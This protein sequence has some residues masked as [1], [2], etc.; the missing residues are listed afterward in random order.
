MEAVQ[1]Q[2]SHCLL[3]EDQDATTAFLQQALSTAFPGI[4]VTS[5]RNLRDAQAWLWERSKLT[6][7]R[8]PLPLAL[9]DLGLP[10]GS[11]IELIRQLKVTE[12]E[13]KCVVVTIYDDD[14]YLF[15][16]LSAG[17][18]GYILKDENPPFIVNILKRV[19]TDEPPLSPAIA[20]RL[21]SHFHAP[22]PEPPAESTKG[23]DL[24]PRERET[25]TLISRGLTV[26]ETAQQLGLS[27]QTVAGYVKIIYQKLHVSN[28]VEAA[29][30]A[31]RRG[32]V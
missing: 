4:K 31:I 25:L 2:L 29:R 14:A 15:E 32:L 24:T 20:R 11:G 18:S 12:P 23:A 8:E 30:E 21:L 7:G 27:P 19:L 26:A 6:G 9:V 1:P 17:A 28:R 13:T 5:R 10:D 16:A 3:V 22:A